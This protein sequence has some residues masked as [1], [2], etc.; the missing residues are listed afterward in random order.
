MILQEAGDAITVQDP[1]GQLRYANKAAAEAMGFADPGEVVKVPQV[2]LMAR[3]ELLDAAGNLMAPDE[4]PER[5]AL[6][7]GSAHESLV[8]FRICETGE[9]RWSLV[10]P[11][12]VRGPDGEPQFVINAF[13][14]VTALKETEKR[15]TLLADAGAILGKSVDYQDALNEL[16]QMVV[17][18]L[19]DW[20]VVDVVEPASGVRRVAVAHD[21]PKLVEMAEEVQRRW[22]SSIEEGTTGDVLRTGVPLLVPIVTEEQLLGAARD[23]EHGRY[24]RALGLR[25]VAI[26]P[27]TSRGT[28]LGLLT[29]VRSDTSRPF[30]EADL[31]LLGELAARAA[32]AVDNARLLHDA[33]EAVRLRDDFLAIASHDMRTP[34]A[35][36][37]G[38]LQLALRR[39]RKMEAGEA[40]KL[41]EY[42]TSAESMTG[43]LTDLV[44]D[45]MDVSLLR[46]GRPVALEPV[47]LELAELVER[48]MNEH[49]R[50]ARGHRFAVDRPGE[51]IVVDAD[52]RRLERVFDNLLSNALKFSPGGGE[53]RISM[54]RDGAV[55][56]VEVTDH[57]LGI[58]ADDLPDLFMRFRRASN[59]EGVS[60]TGLGLSGSRNIIR[61]MGGEIDVLSREGEGSTFTVTLPL[62]SE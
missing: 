46:S 11:T 12:V 21:D 7:E 22:P 5:R 10:R 47:Q 57:G 29:L 60:G 56:R 37:L 35:A 8:R 36:V 49:R 23:E 1:T 15:L 6:R 58:P 26:L 28:V 13:H 61:Q 44:A 2:D 31:P 30:S 59:A 55:A 43:R 27:L 51:P 9:E 34:L 41:M 40:E 19:A 14:D 38:Y 53:I 24:L 54:R 62:P 52:A 39:A 4:L 33:T 17:R 50:L 45:L 16:A 20:C 25:S 18:D 42:L 32:T 3:F 48:V